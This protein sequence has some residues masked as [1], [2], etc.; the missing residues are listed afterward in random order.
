MLF[1][2]FNSSDGCSLFEWD[3]VFNKVCLPTSELML[4]LVIPILVPKLVLCWYSVN[5]SQFGITNIWYA[6]YTKYQ[7]GTNMV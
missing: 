6:L 3:H 5:I 1:F 4:N 7:F 2:P